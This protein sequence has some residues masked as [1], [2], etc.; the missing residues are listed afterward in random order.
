MKKRTIILLLLVV[1][2]F[3][4]VLIRLLFNTNEKL[5]LTYILSLDSET[6]AE[7]LVELEAALPNQERD[8]IIELSVPMQD[9]YVQIRDV[10][11]DS[12]K[13]EMEVMTRMQKT[14]G[15]QQ[16]STQSGHPKIGSH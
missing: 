1:I 13:L 5:F 10:T 9:Q 11:L 14:T 4:L 7:A 15:G 6:P 16:P 12:G 2:T 3:V 8:Q